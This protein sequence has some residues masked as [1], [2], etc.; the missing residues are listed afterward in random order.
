MCKVGASGMPTRFR[1]LHRHHR[2]LTFLRSE[3]KENFYLAEYK[4]IINDYCNA[5]DFTVKFY[6]VLYFAMLFYGF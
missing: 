1:G 4:Y 5:M 3:L 2:H 6:F